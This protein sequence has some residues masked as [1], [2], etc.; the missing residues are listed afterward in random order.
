[1]EPTRDEVLAAVS[2]D[3]LNIG[4]VGVAILGAQGIDIADAWEQPVGAFLAAHGVSLS[5]LQKTV[6]RLVN[7]ALVE[8]VRGAQLRDLDLPTLGT[9]SGGRYFLKPLA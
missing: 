5:G 3:P 2:R 9:K 4:A 7:D 6:D 8:E 1:M